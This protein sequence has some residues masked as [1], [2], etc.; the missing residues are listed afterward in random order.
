[1]SGAYFRGLASR[2]G[3]AADQESREQGPRGVRALTGTY[4]TGA[5]PTALLT[6][7]GLV[8]R[9]GARRKARSPH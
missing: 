4:F 6:E 9:A 2:P 5:D 8:P 7:L 1:M 3:T